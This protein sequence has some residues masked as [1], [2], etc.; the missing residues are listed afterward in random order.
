[1]ILARKTDRDTQGHSRVVSERHRDTQGHSKTFLSVLECPALCPWVSLSVPPPLCPWV[2]LKVPRQLDPGLHALWE[3]GCFSQNANGGIIMATGAWCSTGP[4]AN[5]LVHKL[6]DLRPEAI[7]WT[8]KPMIC[9]VAFRVDAPQSKAN[10]MLSM[11]FWLS[12]YSL[13]SSKINAYSIHPRTKHCIAT[14]STLT[15]SGLRLEWDV[16]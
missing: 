11:H 3:M 9:Y 15:T 5:H 6:K 10:I 13:Q 2:S 4:T 7:D 16:V 8:I 14:R 12:G 1:M